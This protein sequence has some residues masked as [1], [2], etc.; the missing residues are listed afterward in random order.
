[1][2]YDFIF[3]LNCFVFYSKTIHKELTVC[4]QFPKNYP[5]DMV[6]IELKTKVLAYQLVDK[7]TSVAE[8]EAK[9]HLGSH[10]VNCQHVNLYDVCVIGIFSM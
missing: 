10:Q 1:M 7:L 8:L 2:L 5:D 9:K 6:M 4:L 3:I